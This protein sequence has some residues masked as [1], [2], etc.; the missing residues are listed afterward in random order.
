MMAR[1][2]CWLLVPALL[3]LA[4]P[5]KAGAFLFW[6]DAIDSHWAEKPIAPNAD[7]ASWADADV[8]YETAIDFRAKNDSKN[9]Y[10]RLTAD[11]VDGRA[12]MSGAFRQDLT[13]WFLGPDG[14]TRSWGILLPFSTLGAPA[15][16]S[17][18][19]VDPE[20]F[21]LPKVTPQLVSKQGVEIST[22]S[23]PD[24]VEVHCALSGK[25]P[26]YTVIIPLEKANPADGKL[27]L[28]FTAAPVGDRVK[29]MVV[30]WDRNTHKAHDGG[31]AGRGASQRR[32]DDDMDGTSLPDNLKLKLAVRLAG[33][34]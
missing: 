19:R 2:T 6:R 20:D 10:L 29:R 28:D 21:L 5:K 4:L 31:R 7:E 13:F 18:Q 9:L 34:K 8:Q 14:K 25:D 1:A 17:W 16:G 24:G 22:A 15:P 27:L 12:M 33:S 26:V 23:L 30:D 3:L 11:G 32:D